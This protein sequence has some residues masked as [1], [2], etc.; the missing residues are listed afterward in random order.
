VF[1]NRNQSAMAMI[2]P[3]VATFSTAGGISAHNVVNPTEGRLAIKIKTSDNNLYK[4]S[5]VFAFVN[6]G[7]AVRI[8]IKRLSGPAKKDKLVVQYAPAPQKM[9]APQEAFAQGGIFPQLSV[10]LQAL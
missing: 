8:E 5:S 3:A 2:D 7:T 1:Y 6:P 10:A 9:A 4:V